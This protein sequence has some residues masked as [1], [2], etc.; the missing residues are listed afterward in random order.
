M[1]LKLSKTDKILPIKFHDY[2]S[3]I[4]VTVGRQTNKKLTV[5]MSN[6]LVIPN[7]WK[8]MSCH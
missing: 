2:D 1:Y 5:C 3:L 6:G 7:N 4:L 8:Q